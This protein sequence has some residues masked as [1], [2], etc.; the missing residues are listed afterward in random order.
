[1][2]NRPRKRA[3]CCCTPHAH[4][5]PPP[6][7]A[8]VRRSARCAHRARFLV[9]Y[10]FSRE[11]GNRAKPSRYVRGD[12]ALT[13]SSGWIDRWSGGKFLLP[14]PR[15]SRVNKAASGVSVPER[16]ACVCSTRRA[17]H[18]AKRFQVSGYIWLH[19]YESGSHWLCAW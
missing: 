10:R 7:H 16:S 4:R 12:R 5:F 1:M 6:R 11:H 8:P 18:R 3:A 17:V 2:E 13:P 14:L 9:F 19:V 15:E